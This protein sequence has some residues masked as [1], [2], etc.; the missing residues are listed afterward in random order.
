MTMSDILIHNLA[1]RFRS[2]IEA[3]RDSGF[4]AKDTFNCFPKGCCGDASCLLAEFMRSKGIDSIYVWG[5]DN[6]GQTHAWLVVK[7]DRVTVPLPQFLEIPDEI[8]TVLNSYSNEAYATPVDISHYEEDDLENGLIIDITA[9]QFGE[10]PV[11]VDY[12]GGFHRRFEFQAAHDFEGLGDSRMIDLY[13]IIM[14]S[15]F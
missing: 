8:R 1:N 2:Y 13:K 4:F 10:V 11:Y 9:D 12:I 7:D 14:Q 6:T 5:E 15:S 3:A